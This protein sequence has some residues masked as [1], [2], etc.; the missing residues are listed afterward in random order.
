[1]IRIHLLTGIGFIFVLTALFLLPHF[2]IPAALYCIAAFFLALKE[3]S[4]YTSAFQF[5]TVYLAALILGLGL[6]WPLD[7][8]PAFAC[9]LLLSA[10]GSLAR[11]IFFRSFGYVRF[12][13]FE[14]SIAILSFLVYLT[15][16]LLFPASWKGW[17]FPLPVLAIQTV[18][19]FG[20]LK[21][22]TQ[23]LN[24]TRG[25]YKIA[26]GAEAPDFSLPDQEGQAFRLSSLRGQR[27]LLLVFVR[28]DWCPGCHM[29]LRTYQKECAKFNE[30]NIFVLAIGPDPIGVNREMVQKLGLEFKVLSDEKQKTAMI[31]GVQLDNYDNDFAEKYEE[32][33]PLPASF[34][35]DKKGIVRYVSRP[36]FIGEFLNPRTIFPILEELA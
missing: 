18:L 30:K 22:K 11:M 32:G 33:I 35:I 17:L 29:M 34:L 6:D 7:H 13:W 15:A 21:D 8:F 12:S 2:P 14:P 20:I 23:L 16:N 26:V 31:Y 5:F 27:N 19:A 3:V 9:A 10:T 4:K 28:G 25:G 24:F 36:D 1:M